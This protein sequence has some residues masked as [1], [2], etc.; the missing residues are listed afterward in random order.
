MHKHRADV[1]ATDPSDVASIQE[2]YFVLYTVLSSLHLTRL[3]LVPSV[4]GDV[5][6]DKI[7]PSVPNDAE[8]N[9]QIGKPHAGLM[10]VQQ[11]PK[12]DYIIRTG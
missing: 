6:L 8:E 3:N 10:D 4:S 12:D 2:Q 5:L 9:S 1:Q 11:R 7:P